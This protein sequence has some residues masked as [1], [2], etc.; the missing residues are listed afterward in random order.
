MRSSSTLYLLPG[1][2]ALIG[3]QTGAALLMMIGATLAVN[4]AACLRSAGSSWPPRIV[5]GPFPGATVNCSS[6]S[7]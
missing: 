2:S 3:I 7:A 1:L 5:C 4:R 6:P